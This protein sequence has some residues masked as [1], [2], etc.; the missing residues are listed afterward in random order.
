V[1]GKAVPVARVVAHDRLDAVGPLGRLLGELDELGEARAECAEAGE[2][3]QVA[4]LLMSAGFIVLVSPGRNFRL[5]CLVPLAI[6]VSSYNP[7]ND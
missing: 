7:G 6:A 5:A 1:L 3:D 4:D 2:A